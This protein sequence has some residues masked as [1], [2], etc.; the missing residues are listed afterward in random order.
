MFLLTHPGGFFV[1]FDFFV[2][3]WFSSLEELPGTSL[4]QQPSLK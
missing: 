4:M 2:S 1:V 3:L